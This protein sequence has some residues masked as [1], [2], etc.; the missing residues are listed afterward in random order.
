MMALDASLCVRKGSESRQLRLAGSMAGAFDIGLLPGE[1]IE[2]VRIPL[3][4]PESGWGYTKIARKTGEFAHAMAAVCRDPSRD[5]MRIVIGATESSPVLLEEECCSP[6]KLDVEAIK[7]KVLT[8]LQEAGVSDPID[9][10]IRLVALERALNKSI[11]I[12][13]L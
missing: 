12:G 3:L 4:S 10:S 8:R 9:N 6:E 1:W 13:S 5:R 11:Q 7:H 2:S